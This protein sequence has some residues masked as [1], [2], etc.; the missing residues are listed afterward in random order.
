MHLRCICWN[1]DFYDDYD[2]HGERKLYKIITISCICVPFSPAEGGTST[3]DHIVNR[4][5][6]GAYVGTQIFMMIMICTESGNYTRSSPS[7]ASAFRS[8][9]PKAAH[10]HLIISLTD[11]P[12]VLILE[13]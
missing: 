9:P 7:A 10:R 4:C 2:L 12:A 8:P 13:R 3:S 11:A 1:A 5:T 6:C